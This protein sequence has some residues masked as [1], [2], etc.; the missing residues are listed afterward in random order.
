MHDLNKQ[1][2]LRKRINQ[3]VKIVT[4]ATLGVLLIGLIYYRWPK[5]QRAVADVRHTF[6]GIA[7]K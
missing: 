1:A 3:V 2:A 7:E 4:G 5:A 6:T